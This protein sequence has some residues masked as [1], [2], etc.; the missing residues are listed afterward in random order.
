[1]ARPFIKKLD[2]HIRKKTFELKCFKDSGSMNRKEGPGRPESVTTEENTDL[3]EEML[4]SQ[5]EALQTHL[6]PRKI[7]K[8][9]GIS[10][11]SIKTMIKRKNSLQFKRVKTPKMND[12]CHNRR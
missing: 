11:S 1:M 7:D 6:A 5:E 3:I 2:L 12:G 9:T 10:F 8:Q 4:C